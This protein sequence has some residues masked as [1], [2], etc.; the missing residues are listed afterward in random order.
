MNLDVLSK[1]ADLLRKLFSRN[2][3]QIAQV[4]VPQRP[5]PA[6]YVPTF[7]FIRQLFQDLLGAEDSGENGTLKN[8]ATKKS[9]GRVGCV[10]DAKLGCC[11]KTLKCCTENKGYC[12][13]TQK[14]CIDGADC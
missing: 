12:A 4:A 1:G 7:S 3:K 13:A 10:A 6:D 8:T 2:F 11:D 5:L 9:L 14:C